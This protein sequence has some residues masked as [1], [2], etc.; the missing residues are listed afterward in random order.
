MTVADG[1]DPAA[2][3]FELT[4]LPDHADTNPLALMFRIP[5][6]FFL[7]SFL[8]LEEL[9]QGCELATDISEEEPSLS[10]FG[11]EKFMARTELRSVMFVPGT[12]L[13]PSPLALAKY[14]QT[15]ELDLPQQLRLNGLSREPDLS[16]DAGLMSHIELA[17]PVQLQR[18][19]VSIQMVE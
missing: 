12:P 5:Q 2:S 11:H 3:A 8:R 9:G 18:E 17:K 10:H 4:L 13:L 6:T 19:P 14:P 7:C 15:N 1:A 16:A